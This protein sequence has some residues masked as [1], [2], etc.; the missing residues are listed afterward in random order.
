MNSQSPAELRI[1]VAQLQQKL[2]AQQAEIDVL[3]QCV[4]H[5]PTTGSR[6]SGTLLWKSCPSLPQGVVRPHLVTRGNEI[7][8]GG[9]NT[10]TTEMSRK[11][12]KYSAGA[13]AWEGLPITP[14][15]MFALAL[16]K[17]FITVIG[18]ISVLSSLTSADLL[19]YSEN[20]KK[21]HKNF[22]A[23]PTKR[24]AMSAVSCGNHVVVAGGIDEDGQSYLNTVEVL[25]M[26]TM[27]WSAI[28]PLPKPS[29]FMSITACK[30]TNRIYLLG[31]LTKLGA[32]R[33]VFS[34]TLQSLLHSS[35]EPVWEE[36]AQTPYFRSGVVVIGGKLVVASGL[37]EQN[38]VTKTIHA[39]DL[40]SKQWK[41]VGEMAAS[42]SSCSLA[43]F[44]GSHLMVVG[45]YVNPK[46][47]M[48]S[49]TTDV[50]ECINLHLE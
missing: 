9:G 30:E 28:A 34:C 44:Y 41:A 15:H 48:N 35:E 11:V 38:R 2:L 14:Y 42:R 17:D 49:L 39:F 47:W 24:C 27:K 21:W 31:G 45:G 36:I 23:M 7:Y 32:L 8:I 22:P 10:G 4:P 12:H 19:H 5:T 26:S 3:K 50:M 20:T 1:Q 16:V 29:T 46:N 6:S 13:K 40:E 18:G 37:D 25:D 43:S 33:S